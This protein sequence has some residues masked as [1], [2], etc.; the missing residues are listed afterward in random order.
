MQNHRNAVSFAGRLQ[1]IGCITACN[2]VGSSS[3]Y[4][5]MNAAA[6]LMQ[7]LRCT[8]THL[9]IS[10]RFL[11]H[12]SNV[13][14]TQALTRQRQRTARAPLQQHL[15]FLH[16]TPRHALHNPRSTTSHPYLPYHAHTGRRGDESTARGQHAAAHD[17]HWHTRRKLCG[18]VTE[19]RRRFF[20][21]PLRT[22]RLPLE[23]ERRRLHEHEWPFD[24]RAK[25]CGR[26]Q[27]AVG[28]EGK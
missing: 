1:N 8:A 27:L 20:P 24:L 23:E 17:A 9:K 21:M 19:G 13:Q 22:W 4:T 11:Q 5:R 15:H 2:A 16:A 12:A 10:Q 28:D 7:P 3:L 6:R 25:L 14:H 26:L 18:H